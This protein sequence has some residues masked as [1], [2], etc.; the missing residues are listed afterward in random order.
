MATPIKWTDEALLE[1]AKKYGSVKEFRVGNNPAYVSAYRSGRLAMACAHMSVSR[2][3]WTLEELKTEAMKYKRRKDFSDANYSAYQF[4]YRRGL[5]DEICAHMDA[6]PKEWTQETLLEE[7][8]KYKTR[9]AFQNGNPSAY[10]GALRRGIL[11]D[12]CSH[13][14][15]RYTYWTN[16]MLAA[17]AKQYSHRGDFATAEP[18]AY[19]TARRRG[20]LESACSHMRSAL[21]GGGFKSDRPAVLYLVQFDGG[22]LDR[23]VFK[24]GIT[25]RTAEI[26]AYSCGSWFLDRSIRMSVIEEVAFD[27]GEKAAKKETQILRAL[28]DHRYLGKRFISSG[29]SEVVTIDPRS[30]P[31]WRN[32]IAK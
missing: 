13:M 30:T 10:M 16:E 26:R 8:K 6:P 18:V 19:T 7:A 32:T 1:A 25:N 29:W 5:T 12:V 9:L 3:L 2:K 27:R 21:G 22:H 4:A 31:I 23:P 15:K 20:I 11:N 28:K 14:S 17:R 24:V